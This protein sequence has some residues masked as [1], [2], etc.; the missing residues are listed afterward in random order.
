MKFLLALLRRLGAWFGGKPS[1]EV[2]GALGAL[3][4]FDPTSSV[5]ADELLARY[6]VH[7]RKYSAVT[8]KLKPE[9]FVPHPHKEMSVF[10]IR[11]LE[12]ENIRDLGQKEFADRLTEAKPLLGWGQF[13]HR[14]LAEPS[15]SLRLARWNRSDNAHP[16]HRDVVGWP[17]I[18]ND[19]KETKAKQKEVALELA[20]RTL[21]VLVSS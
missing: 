3:P 18:Q 1:L 2:K 14:V 7:P 21:L 19:P 11:E 9:A 17:V 8:K 20:E 4:A 5:D 16:R 6:F 10:R 13:K 12:T 15:V